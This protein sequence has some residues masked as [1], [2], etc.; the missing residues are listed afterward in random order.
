MLSPAPAH[1]P[2]T[3]RA[4][5]NTQ[6]EHLQCPSLSISCWNINGW[7][8]NNAILRQRILQEA[9]SDIFCLIKTHMENSQNLNCENYTVF[10]HNRTLKILFAVMTQIAFIHI[11]C[12]NSICTMKLMPWFF[13]VI[14]MVKYVN[15]MMLIWMWIKTWLK[16]LVLTLLKTRMGMHC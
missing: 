3:T 7:A 12:L 2:P 5:Y 16:E 13:V 1:P 15:V 10:Q 4:A 11:F 6:S 14:I 8:T 9:I